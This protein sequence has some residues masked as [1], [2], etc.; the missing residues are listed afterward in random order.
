MRLYS[1][2]RSSSAWRARI[3]LA[4]KGV[5]HEILTVHLLRAGGEQFDADFAARNPMSQ[6]PVLEVDEDGGTFR[7]TQSMAILEF[8]EERFPEPRLLPEDRTQRARVREL[9]EIVNSGIQPLQ[10]LALR[11]A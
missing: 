8:L 5:P 11:K 9:A 6:V 1:Y 4:W 7:L 3:A 10:N 2:F